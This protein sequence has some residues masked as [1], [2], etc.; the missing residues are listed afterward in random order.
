MSQFLADKIIELDRGKLMEV[1]KALFY[2][3]VFLAGI[4]LN[5]NHEHTGTLFGLAVLSSLSLVALAISDGLKK[6]WQKFLDSI[7]IITLMMA[8]VFGSYISLVLATGRII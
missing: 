7:A 1:S 2:G 5:L 3:Y 8:V 6:D 4:S